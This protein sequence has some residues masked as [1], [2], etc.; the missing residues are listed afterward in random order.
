MTVAGY[1][2]VISYGVRYV[3]GRAY[4][5]RT[6]RTGRHPALVR[7]RAGAGVGLGAGTGGVARETQASPRL[8]LRG[9]VGRADSLRGSR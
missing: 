5:D 7:E 2:E 9:R 4:D 3:P 8:L 1:R 6:D